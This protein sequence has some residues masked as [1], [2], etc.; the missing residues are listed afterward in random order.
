[1]RAVLP[2]YVKKVRKLSKELRRLE[3]PRHI[4]IFGKGFKPGAKH[5]ERY[6]DQLEA[7]LEELKCAG[8][9]AS[10]RPFYLLC[11]SYHLRT[12]FPGTVARDMDEKI[13]AR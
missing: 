9:R 4:E 8:T 10:L 13:R 12:V 7:I 1:L 5:L 6:A 11:M 3:A 2:D